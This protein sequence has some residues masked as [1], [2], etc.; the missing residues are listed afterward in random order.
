[1]QYPTRIAAIEMHL[2]SSYPLYCP[3]AYARMQY[4]PSSN[5][6][7]PNL[8]LDGTPKGSG[9]TSW[10]SYIVTRMNQPAPM[11]I[12][13]WGTYGSGSG[14]IYARFRNDSTASV[15]A[16][17]YFVITEDSIYYVT[18]YGDQWHNHVARDYVPNQIG[19]QVTIPAGDSVTVSQNF[20]IQSGWNVNR[21]NIVTWIQNNSTREVYQAGFIKVTNLT[22]VEEFNN[23]NVVSKISPTPNPCVNGTSFQ[24]NINKGVEWKIV[25]FDALGREMKRIEGNGTGKTQTV[26]WNLLDN[27]NNR[28]KSGV[29][30]YRL[31]S[32]ELNANGKIVVR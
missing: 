24:F 11:R 18:P 15:T 25:I 31:I 21:C 3:E 14:T 2:N 6:Y 30:F 20:T 4:Y 12:S 27:N 17:V 9:Y 19:Q 10:Q 26:E 28:V 7:T 16:Y 13:M 1:M 32:S 8:I 22:V 29:Y 23:E 5:W